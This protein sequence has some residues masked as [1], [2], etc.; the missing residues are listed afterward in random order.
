VKRLDDI[1]EKVQGYGSEDDLARI[2]KAWVFASKYHRGQLRKSGAP[3]LG[4]PVEVADILADLRLD[5]IAIT[6]AILHDTVEDTPATL[7]EIGD[8]FGT[9][10]ADI[11]DG[12][13]KLD[14]LDFR[15]AEEAQAENFRKLV[16]AMSKDIRVIIVKL[17]DRLHN[18]RTLDVMRPEKRVRIAQET[19]DLYAPIANRLGIVSIKG[20]L[21][22][23]CFKYL[24]PEIFEELERQV[25]AR[26]PWFET[27]IERVK[28]EIEEALGPHVADFEVTG[29]VKR[30][31]SVWVKMQ[32][33]QLT[34]EEVHDLL[35]FRVLVPTVGECYA[36]LGSV[37]GLWAPLTEQ[38]KDYIAQP[39]TNGYQSL[40]TLV[41]GPENQRIEVQIRTYEM[42]RFGEF[43]V[44]AH[45][46]YKEGKLS[47]KR[48]EIEKYTEIR[49]LLQWAEDVDDSRDFL[50]VLKIDL[51]T[52][53]VY[54]YTPRG[55]IRWYPQGATILDF[56]Y[57]IHTEVGSRCTGGRVNGRLVKMSHELES[58]DTIEIV[59]RADQQ[60]SKDWVK[61]ARTS[62]ALSKIRQHL[63]KEERRQSVEVGERLFDQE[64]R[65]YGTSLK[66]VLKKEGL[67]AAFE[68][69]STQNEIEFYSGIGYGRIPVE[70]LLPLYIA[71]EKLAAHKV[72]PQDE[73]QTST[74][75]SLM[76][77]MGRRGGSP[78]KI[79]GVEG[80][81]TVFAKCCRP[82]PG[83][84]IMGFITRGRGIT[85]HT[86][87]CAQ[88]L[89]LP[90]ERRVEVQW[91]GAHNIPHAARIHVVTVDRPMILSDL[92]RTIGKMDVNITGADIRTTRDDRGLI[93]LD[94]AVK[95]AS[96]LRN[97]MTSIERV[98]GVISVDRVQGTGKS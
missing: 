83:D 73:I 81:L 86:S 47:L 23:L 43:G 74:L 65:K 35:A 54:A 71:A 9:E 2:R 75:S 88:A 67:Q 94:V 27:Y 22:D 91:D 11:V 17:A 50:D 78:V 72:A 42:H 95:D 85:V 15:S 90:P 51:Y 24:H 84:P 93:T 33:K 31:W 13:T 97:V 60:P 45:W 80:M 29:R 37:H 19:K 66:A 4:H 62:R 5:S 26:R 10:V 53:Q 56:A 28:V 20:A 61:L 44:A 76:R 30:L 70:R 57:S 41:V 39:K 68:A 40:H 98:R 3:Y 64:L 25:E 12:V 77:R 46:K 63:R 69:T 18:M 55:D 92:T 38:F 49:K 8:L 79:D 36:V 32:Q 14:K 1:L 96:Q 52:D 6:A 34:F 82:L 59:T 7:A 48:D 16:L 87:R 21:E 58:G 89:T